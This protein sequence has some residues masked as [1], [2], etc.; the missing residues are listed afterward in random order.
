VTTSPT[1]AVT[2][3][4]GRTA[5]LTAGPLLE[6]MNFLNEVTGRFPRRGAMNRLLFTGVWCESA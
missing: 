2:L 3:E 4:L 6:A 5:L 1:T